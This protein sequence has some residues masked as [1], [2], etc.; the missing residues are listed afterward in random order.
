MPSYSSAETY[1]GNALTAYAQKRRIEAAETLIT[2][3]LKVFKPDLEL[4]KEND[5]DAVL[6]TKNCLQFC[7]VKLIFNVFDLSRSFGK[8]GY[9]FTTLVHTGFIESISLKKN[10]TSFI[11]IVLTRHEIVPVLEGHVLKFCASFTTDKNVPLSLV[12]F[13]DQRFGYSEFSIID[14]AGN[15][16][17]KHDFRVVLHLFSSEHPLSR[18]GLIGPILK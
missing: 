4:L 10:I 17:D 2:D 16:D 15:I 7:G 11:P 13:I 3:Q 9:N 1:L 18:A 6:S 14:D 5:D 8:C 12:G